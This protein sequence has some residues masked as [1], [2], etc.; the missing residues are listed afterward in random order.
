M[1]FA[2]FDLV[3]S[4]AGG[5]ALKALRER[6]GARRVAP[7]LRLCRSGAIALR[8]VP[9]DRAALSYLGTYAE[10]RQ[11]ALDRLV[12]RPGAAETE[13]AFLIG[14]TLYPAIF[15][16]SNI[17]FSATWP[18]RASPLLRGCSAA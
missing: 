5:G 14:G 1:V 18:P 10:D 17:F 7:A 3:L 8:P 9:A 11:A 13:V 12:S 6:L 4:Y 15:W 2:D 16:A